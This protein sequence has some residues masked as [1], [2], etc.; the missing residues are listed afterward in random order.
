MNC[1]RLRRWALLLTL[2]VVPLAGA[3][4]PVGYVLPDVPLV[5][6]TFNACGPSSITQVLRYYGIPATLAEVSRATRPS[7]RSYMTAQAIVQFAPTRGLGA[8]L[9]RGGSV[10][11]VRRGVAMRVPLIVLHDVTVS[12]RVVPHWRVA[13]GFDDARRVVHVVDPLLGR[14][15]VPYATFE[16]AWSPHR[17]LFAVMFPPDWRELVTRELG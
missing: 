13:V 5:R 15:L 7:E 1:A 12:G 16:R 17:G 4:A 6:Q 2:S 3:A 9:Y 8:R 10:Q 14:V 11:A